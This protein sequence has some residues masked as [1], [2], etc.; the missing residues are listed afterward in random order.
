M[1][2]RLF[3]GCVWFLTIWIAVVGLEILASHLVLNLID[4]KHSPLAEPIP[5]TGKEY[6]E[7]H[8]RGIGIYAAVVSLI[9]TLSGSLPGTAASKRTSDLF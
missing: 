6:V 5:R 8:W 3:F 4:L 1:L 7:R 2:R 9:G